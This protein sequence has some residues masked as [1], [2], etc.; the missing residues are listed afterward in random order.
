LVII[1]RYKSDLDKLTSISNCLASFIP[2]T[3]HIKIT[4]ESKPIKLIDIKQYKLIC[5][6]MGVNKLSLIDPKTHSPVTFDDS[7]LLLKYIP[8]TIRNYVSILDIDKNTFVGPKYTGFYL[9]SL[10]SKLKYFHEDSVSYLF[11]LS[12]LNYYIRLTYLYNYSLIFNQ[13]SGNES[14]NQLID[15]SLHTFDRRASNT[16]RTSSTRSSIISLSESEPRI[17]PPEQ[18][19]EK[20]SLFKSCIVTQYSQMSNFF[21]ICDYNIVDNLLR[22][23][24]IKQLQDCISKWDS[25]QQQRQ[26]QQQPLI[27]NYEH[28]VTFNS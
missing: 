6:T 7:S 26:Q 24:Q 14:P 25:Q 11:L 28:L 20:L 3:T 13:N 4:Y 10:V 1:S 27:V 12:R 5:L 19:R 21:D 16:S 17:E 8:I 15:T 18:I 23:L 9:T 2:N 22:T